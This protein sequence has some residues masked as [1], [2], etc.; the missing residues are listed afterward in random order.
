MDRLITPKPDSLDDDIK[1]LFFRKMPG[2]ILGVVNP[3]DYKKLYNL[4]QRCNEE[5][6]T[7]GADANVMSASAVKRFQALARGDRHGTSPGPRHASTLP[8]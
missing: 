7:R 2:F 4:M 1:A 6:E 3:K 5:W 8:E